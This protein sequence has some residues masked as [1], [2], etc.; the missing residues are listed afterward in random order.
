MDLVVRLGVL[1][2]GVWKNP[3]PNAKARAVLN[4]L[5]VQPLLA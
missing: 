2:L 3:N 4:M 1:V 5:L